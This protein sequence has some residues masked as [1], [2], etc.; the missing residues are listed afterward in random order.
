MAGRTYRAYDPSLN[1]EP[2]EFL[3]DADEYYQDILESLKTITETALFITGWVIRTRPPLKMNNA[4]QTLE[5]T[6]VNVLKQPAG[7]CYILW[8]SNI[9]GPA[10]HLMS[11]IE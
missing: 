5:D 11:D 9:T 4:G 2:I 6:I 3:S 7:I 1:T 10:P 8:N